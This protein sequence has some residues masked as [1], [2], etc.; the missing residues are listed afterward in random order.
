MDGQSFF[1]EKWANK[2]NENSALLLEEI[3]VVTSVT[4][5][6]GAKQISVGNL[7]TK[8]ISRIVTWNA[9]NAFLHS[10]IVW[11]RSYELRAGINGIWT[12]TVWMQGKI[13][14]RYLFEMKHLIR[15]FYFWFQIKFVLLNNNFI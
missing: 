3:R 7:F 9:R 13:I 8:F 6:V 10:V 15:S 12:W 14:K 4:L 5:L 1:E 2:L 11:K